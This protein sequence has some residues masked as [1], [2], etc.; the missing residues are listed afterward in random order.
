MIKLLVD[1]ISLVLCCAILFFGGYQ[2]MQKTDLSEMKSDFDIAMTA[3]IINHR[4]EVEN[5]SDGPATPDDGEG[6]TPDGGE[7]TTPD[8]GEGT[9][10]DGGEGTTPDGGEGTTPDGGEGTTPDGGETPSVNK[11]EETFKEMFDTYDPSFADINKQVLSNAINGSLGLGGGSTG[12]EE[13][14]E[15]GEGGE[16]ETPAIGDV[17]TDYVDN[18][19]AEI[20]KIQKEAEESGATEE[21]IAAKRDEFAQKESAALDGMMNIV[22]SSNNSEGTVDNE[23]IKESVEAILDSNVCLGTVTN[24]V[25]NNEEL[26]GSIQDA[27][28]NMDEE[29]KSSIEQMIQEKTEENPENKEMYDALWEL[30]NKK[31]AETEVQE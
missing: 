4:P 26:K 17:I 19:Y 7:G 21:E 23:V 5:P 9:T 8:G 6:T 27:T 20:D 29:T 10:P 16:A 25:T 31:S 18:L 28:A 3:P 24:T 11:S 30:F 2:T 14:G 13:G 15:G 1:I 22:N 12:G